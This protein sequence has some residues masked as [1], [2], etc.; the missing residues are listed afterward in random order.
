M[1][2]SKDDTLRINS[3]SKKIPKGYN[4]FVILFIQMIYNPQ[5]LSSDIESMLESNILWKAFLT[6]YYQPQ[7]HKIAVELGGYHPRTKKESFDAFKVEDDE[8]F[9]HSQKNTENDESSAYSSKAKPESQN[10]NGWNGNKGMDFETHGDYD[11]YYEDDLSLS[12]SLLKQEK[13]KEK[14]EQEKQEKEKQEKQEKEEQEKENENNKNNEI[15]NQ[16]LENKNN[17]LYKIE[18]NNDFIEYDNTKNLGGF[19]NYEESNNISSKCRYE[20][21]DYYSFD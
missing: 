3:S 1:N 7:I 19:L 8:P 9:Y 16:N 5:T 13:E 14:Q 10:F 21:E 4:G 12:L 2:L 20:Y 17:G 15:N 18:E 6:D 11:Y